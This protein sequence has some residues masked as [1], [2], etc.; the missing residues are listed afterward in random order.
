MKLMD[1]WLEEER[2]GTLNTGL[3][4]SPIDPVTEGNIIATEVGPSEVSKQQPLIDA[5]EEVV[6]SNP[7][8]IV[9]K[10]TNEVI[11]G[12]IGNHNLINL[13]EEEEPNVA[14]DNDPPT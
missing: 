10:P 2:L 8:L 1:Q 3:P 12:F 11:F 14:V 5:E 7:P 6:A 13:E 4:P 9:E